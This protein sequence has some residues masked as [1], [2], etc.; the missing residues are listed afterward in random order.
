MVDGTVYHCFVT[1]STRK[2]DKHGATLDI[3]IEDTPTG[4][5][6]IELKIVCPPDHPTGVTTAL[7]RRI[8]AV[9]LHRT[10]RTTQHVHLDAFKA[11]LQPPQWVKGTRNNLSKNDLKT[12]AVLYERALRDGAPPTK[13][14]QEWM[15]CSK[16]TASRA[17]KQAR[18]LGLLGDP[19]K[20]GLP[21]SPTSKK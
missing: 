10:T 7:I 11:T 2:L 9:D 4:V 18:D 14:I 6:C 17:V 15:G 19:R 8:N 1:R 12:L 16:P 13:T 20:K 5:M 21:S 3:V